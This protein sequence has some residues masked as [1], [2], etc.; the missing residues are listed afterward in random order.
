MKLIRNILG[1]GIYIVAYYMYIDMVK[2][3]FKGLDIPQLIVGTVITDILLL[4]GALVIGVRLYARGTPLAKKLVYTLLGFLILP[5]M[6]AICTVSH[7][8]GE[9]GGIDIFK[10]FKATASDDAHAKQ[11]TVESART[12]SSPDAYSVMRGTLNS[13]AS[14]LSGRVSQNT[15]SDVKCNLN[16]NGANAKIDIYINFTVYN[17]NGMDPDEEYDA[18]D[19][20][21][22][23][24][25]DIRFLQNAICEDLEAAGCN[26]N[27]N[28]SVSIHKNIKSC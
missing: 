27:Y 10:V 5:V 19:R 22:D 28:V 15:Y 12:L 21:L 2:G 26:E 25:I 3:Q 20:Y 11:Q 17:N 14:G 24:Y 8:F 13:F 16:M 23:E 18:M 9:G 1:L 4:V 6:I 7:F